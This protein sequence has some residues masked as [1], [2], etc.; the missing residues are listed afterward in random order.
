MSEFVCLPS[1]PRIRVA[2]GGRRCTVRFEHIAGGDSGLPPHEAFKLAWDYCVA[3]HGEWGPDNCRW[4]VLNYH[5]PRGGDESIGAIGFKMAAAEPRDGQV[6]GG[7][8]APWEDLSTMRIDLQAAMRMLRSLEYSC[9]VTVGGGSGGLAQT[10]NICP[11]CGGWKPITMTPAFWSGR[12]ERRGHRPDCELNRRL[13][14][15]DGAVA[16]RFAPAK[17]IGKVADAAAGEM[18]ALTRHIERLELDNRIL[19]DRVE[20]LAVEKLE[21][22]RGQFT[23]ICSYCGFEAPPPNGWSE[24]QAHIRTC[25]KH[26]MRALEAEVERMKVTCLPDAMVLRARRIYAL[27]MASEAME[28]EVRMDIAVTKSPRS[29]RMLAYRDQLYAARQDADRAM[30]ELGIGYHQIFGPGTPLNVPVSG[31]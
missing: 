18:A 12:E 11:R 6:S 20:K 7:P 8:F 28:A 27:L 4:F 16:E 19:R 17:D 29:D 3:R 5:V 10:V 13:M 23:Q 22:V 2:D 21:I 25:E 24:L 15:H 30:H 9:T 14:A 1:D 31:S 26:P